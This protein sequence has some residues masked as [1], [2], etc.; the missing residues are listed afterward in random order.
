M[1]VLSTVHLLVIVLALHFQNCILTLG[2]RRVIVRDDKD[3]TSHYV[4]DYI[5]R[6]AIISA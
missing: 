3:A 6:K 1:Y 4:A 2:C 5:I